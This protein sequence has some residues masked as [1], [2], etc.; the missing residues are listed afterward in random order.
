MYSKSKCAIKCGNQRSVFFDYSRGV[1]Q[2][3]ILSP[4]LFN[5]Y[6]NEIPHTLDTLHNTDAIILSK[7]LPLNCLL[8][9]DD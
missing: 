7:G 8:Y 2:G 1:R 4:L 6:L 9:A 5:F 3:S